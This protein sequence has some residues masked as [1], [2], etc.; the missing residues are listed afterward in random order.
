MQNYYYGS[1]KNTNNNIREENC[2]YDNYG[3]RTNYEILLKKLK[4][5][6]TLYIESLLSLGKTPGQVQEEWDSLRKSNVEII[7]CDFPE[8]DTTKLA[9]PVGRYVAYLLRISDMMH[10]NYVTDLKKARKEGIKKAKERGVRLG[11]PNAIP[12]EEFEKNYK[13]LSAKG[14]MDQD[15]YKI[16]GISHVSGIKYKKIMNGTY[17]EPERNKEKKYE[18]PGRP[19][20]I[21]QEKFTE[22][23]TKYKKEKLSDKVIY[24]KLGI[25]QSAGKIYKKRMLQNENQEE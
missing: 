20:L 15:I 25:S 4:E 16:M 13:T 3:E 21:S 7:A 12:I 9:Y 17:V 14:F 2:Y 11:R 5:G 19:L 8:I 6:D 23:Y 1:K 24:E 22:E 18:H 10:K